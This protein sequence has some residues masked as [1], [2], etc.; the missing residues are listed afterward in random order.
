MIQTF[1]L[2]ET[3]SKEALLIVW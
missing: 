2:K 1:T 3:H